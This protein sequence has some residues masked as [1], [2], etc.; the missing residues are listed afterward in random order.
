VRSFEG[1]VE[2]LRLLDLV[3]AV[4][5]VAANDWEVV[6]ALQHLLDPPRGKEPSM[7]IVAH[8]VDGGFE[9]AYKDCEHPLGRRLEATRS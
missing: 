5:D 7:R 1:R 8:V 3:C 4:Q 6:A 9:A 2:P